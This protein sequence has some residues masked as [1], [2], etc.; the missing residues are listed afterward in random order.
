MNKQEVKEIFCD[1]CF[2]WWKVEELDAGL[3]GELY[4]DKCKSILART[5]KYNPEKPRQYTVRVKGI[6]GR[7][8]WLMYDRQFKKYVIGAFGSRSQNFFTEKQL[9]RDGMAHVLY[10][11]AFEVREVEE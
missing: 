6:D 7:F 9:A 3:N 11:D 2:K 5:D 10:N 8:N 1:E 4:C